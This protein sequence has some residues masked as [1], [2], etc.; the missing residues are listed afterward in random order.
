[1]RAVDADDLETVISNMIYEHPIRADVE[2][3]SD[4]VL[5]LLDAYDIIV[6]ANTIELGENN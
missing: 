2:S 5:G 4:Y 6:K 1:M 3:E